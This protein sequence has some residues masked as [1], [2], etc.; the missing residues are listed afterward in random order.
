[1]ATGDTSNSEMKSKI[2]IKN[3]KNYSINSFAKNYNRPRLWAEYV[4]EKGLPGS[5]EA[6]YA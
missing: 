2:K 6:P 1:M 4:E 5:A 3:N